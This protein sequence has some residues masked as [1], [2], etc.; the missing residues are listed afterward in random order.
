MKVKELKELADEQLELEL[1]CAI[2]IDDVRILCETVKLPEHII[3][4]RFIGNENL[5]I[6]IVRTI[7]MN[8]PLSR[9]FL[10][11]HLE[12]YD[13]DW[14]LSNQYLREDKDL[15]DGIRVAKKLTEED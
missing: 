1:K 2:F 7:F 3:E 5:P 14:V 8:Q 10:M 13:Y 15:L 11:K 12:I 4:E 9:E 6:R